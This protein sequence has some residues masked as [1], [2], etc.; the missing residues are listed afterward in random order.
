M[1]VKKVFI[2]DTNVL[3]YDARAIFNFAENSEIVIPIAVIEELDRFKKGSDETARNA[4]EVLRI[5]DDLRRKGSLSK[6]V[7]TDDGKLI[8]RIDLCIDII[9][10]LP[11]PLISNKADNLILGV[12]LKLR[13][14]LGKKKVVF[15]TK[16]TNLRIKADALDIRSGD[17]E[18]TSLKIEEFY[19]GKIELE[20]GKFQIEEFL[21]NGELS[22]AAKTNEY[23][24]YSNQ[25]VILRE[26]S[27]KDKFYLGK[28]NEKFQKII[29][30]NDNFNVW[31]LKAR[32]VEQ[33]FAFDALL[34]ENIQLVTLVGKAGTGKTLLAIAA[35]LQKTIDDG[36]HKKVLASRP[37][38]P[39]GR[40]M[41]YLPGDIAEKLNPWMQPIYDNLEHI[42]SSNG[43][44]IRKKGE[45]SY[46]ELIHQGMVSVEPLTYIRGRSIANQ[47]LIVDE[48]QN[49][50]PHEIKTIITRAGY[51]TKVVLTGDP[52]QIDNP[53]V[54]SVS[55]G[56]SFIVERFKAHDIHAHIT[57][58][59][60]ERSKL[61]ELAAELLEK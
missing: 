60:G 54:D 16:D 42:L 25:Y 53:Y 15:I 57:L 10:R 33:A 17:Y 9:K 49:L 61:S 26:K 2:L 3:L 32:N 14:E 35:G 47:F 46:E 40:D 21:K 36:C 11:E 27:I 6:G 41:G 30:I 51:K 59:K 12:A 50:T 18:P 37:I 7:V 38:I 56:L 13:E 55:N 45:N 31:G 8:I 52:Y 24:L 34:D 20:F 58:T 28:Y 1:D 19:T 29:Q 39:M 44:T 23:T 48:A 5:L 22:L 4:R 43:E